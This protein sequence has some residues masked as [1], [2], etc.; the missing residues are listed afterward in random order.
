MM[1]RKKLVGLD[2]AVAG[3]VL[4]QAVVDGNG[5]VLLPDEAILTELMLKSLGRRGIEM[6]YVADNDISEA[7][8]KAERE[9]VQQ[10]LTIL[11]R[12]SD[13]NR[14][15]G[16]LLQRITEYRLGTLE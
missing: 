12:K 15:C 8:L 16:L 13:A 6:L 2:E 3:M 10:R 5:A 14:A 11:F 1:R 7:D 4:A 9:R